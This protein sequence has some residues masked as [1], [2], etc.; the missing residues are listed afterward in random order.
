MRLVENIVQL[1]PAERRVATMLA[2]G[3]N[4][5]EIAAAL[6]VATKTV[7]SHRRSVLRRLGLRNTVE[8]AR[9]ALCEGVVPL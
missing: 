2:L 7:D 9:R 3:L 5:H 8:L 4:R 6:H 1:T